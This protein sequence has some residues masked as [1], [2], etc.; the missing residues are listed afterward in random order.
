MDE[1]NHFRRAAER[2]GI[3]QPSLTAQIQ[4]LEETL[5]VLL[6]ERSRTR[7]VFTPVGR[8]VAARVRPILE[9]VQALTDF[10][11]GAQR[12]LVGTI[13]LGVKPTLGPYLLPH[14]VKRL[15]KEY[16]K[17]NLY[18]RENAPRMLER[19]LADGLHDMILAQL[20]VGSSELT[21]R[22]L[23]REPLYLAVAADHRT[24]ARRCDPAGA[25]EG[26]WKFCL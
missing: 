20:P 22:R 2:A 8:E 18:I 12:G 10:T 23:F 16:P 1:T 3:S 26:D 21:T 15:H 19:E 13:R 11:A 14:V 4:N 24:G 9:Q 17:L 25:V 5:G 6:V 7:V